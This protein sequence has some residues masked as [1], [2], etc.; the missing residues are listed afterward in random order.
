MG[1]KQTQKSKRKKKSK[2][3]TQKI[4]KKLNCSPKK[5]LK[6][7]C[8]TNKSL[9]KI[10]YLWNK[11]HPDSKIVTNNPKDIWNQLK[12]NMKHL[13]N[14]E[15]CWLKQKFMIN[16]LD[17]ELK[18]YTF[19]PPSPVEW[20]ED[21]NTWLTSIDI[22]KIMK[23]YEVAYPSFIFI[24]P[25][26]INFDKKQKFGECVWNDLCNFNLDKLIRKGKN[27]IGIIFNTDPHY[28]E[29][30]HWICEFIDIN[31]KF[32]FYFDSN[33]DKT[34]NEINKLN[35]KI[36]DQAKSIGINFNLYENKTKHQKSDT[37]CGMYV[38]YCIIQLLKNKMTPEMFDK[39]IP[40]EQMEQY[41]NI[42][43]NS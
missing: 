15:K 8:Y 29:G 27:K 20:K 12:F 39:R 31:K 37:E 6:F 21:P 28:L 38:L 24:G 33:G 43:F 5:N 17:P 16:N 35:K 34:P 22:N 42:F 10:K 4:F 19:A 1:R 26:P 41:R 11:R 9:N 13:C 32:I 2:N 3:K 18:N 14:T 25:S 23:Q 40:D 36:I 30:S 7:S